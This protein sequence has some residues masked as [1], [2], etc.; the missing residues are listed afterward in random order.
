[1]HINAVLKSD[2]W[3]TA[4]HMVRLYNEIL[5]ADC[6]FESTIM[7]FGEMGFGDDM[8]REG[9]RLAQMGRPEQCLAMGS[10]EHLNISSFGILKRYGKYADFEVLEN[11]ALSHAAF[12][13]TKMNVC[14]CG[15]TGALTACLMVTRNVV[16]HA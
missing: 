13:P 6:A 1:M 12:F 8:S 3:E 7:A 2:F 5:E 16:P 11:F 14:T 15:A 4:S 10:G 9:V